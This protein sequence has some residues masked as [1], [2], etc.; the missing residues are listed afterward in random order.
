MEERRKTPEEYERIYLPML[1]EE[2]TLNTA[3]IGK[4]GAA[5]SQQVAS[6]IDYLQRCEKYFLTYGDMAQYLNQA[7]RP[8]MLKRLNEILKDIRNAIQITKKMYQDTLS[9]EKSIY[10]IQQDMQQEG[11]NTIRQVIKKRWESFNR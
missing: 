8:Q 7:G 10:R 1:E 6:M 11:F 2:D 5:T 3:N 9:A 4:S